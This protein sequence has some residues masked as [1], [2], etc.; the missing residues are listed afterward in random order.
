MKNASLVLAVCVC[1][2]ATWSGSALAEDAPTN[3]GAGA[4]HVGGGVELSVSQEQIDGDEAPVAIFF[5]LDAEVGYFPIDGLKLS[6]VPSFTVSSQGEATSVLV[7][8]GLAVSYYLDLGP[9]APFARAEGGLLFGRQSDG[10]AQSDLKGFDFGG[11]LGLAIPLWSNVIEL[12][13][14]YQGRGLSLE[15]ADSSADG[16]RHGLFVGLGYALVLL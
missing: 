15:R 5:G 3:F 13:V 11:G 10:E 6:G 16:S 7:G 9:A 12:S 8:V 2:V 4:L 14:E 1:A